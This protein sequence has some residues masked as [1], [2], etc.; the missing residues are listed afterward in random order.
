MLLIDGRNN[1][2]IHYIALFPWLVLF[3]LK[4]VDQCK[5][6]NNAIC[7]QMFIMIISVT[8]TKISRKKTMLYYL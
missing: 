7:F 5:A 2:H 3:H 1:K 8:Y 6:N 4:E